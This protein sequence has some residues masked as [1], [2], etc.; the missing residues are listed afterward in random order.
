MST[1]SVMP[2][3]ASVPLF[4]RY[5]AAVAYLL[6]DAVTL[7]DREAVLAAVVWPA[8][9]RAPEALPGEQLCL[10]DEAAL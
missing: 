6:P 2:S 9:R 3:L 4:D 5:K 7:A 10:F 8:G 1:A